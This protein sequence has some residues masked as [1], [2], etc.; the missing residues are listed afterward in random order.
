MKTDPNQK[1]EIMNEDE[2]V[3][4]DKY[5]NRRP[6]G[7]KFWL[8]LTLIICF[9]GF[10]ILFKFYVVDKIIPPEELKASL[11]VFDITSQWVVKEKIKEKDFEGIV[12][13]PQITFRFR[14]IGDKPLKNIFVLGV[15]WLQ[16]RAKALGETSE[17][18]FKEPL[19]PGKDSD[20]VV[21][22]S[23]FG[24]RAKSKNFFIT[25]KDWKE[26][27]VKIFVKSSTSHYIFYNVYYILRKIEGLDRDIEVKIQ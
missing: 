6:F 21:L 14:N 3:L 7:S 13:V 10:A 15:F 17:M 23:N 25:S 19:E 5:I 1:Q 4:F 24:Y 16:N 9:I 12:L 8:Y 26:A 22:T 20:P 27:S 18:V 2:E 11:E